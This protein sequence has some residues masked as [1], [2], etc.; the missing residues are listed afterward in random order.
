MDYEMHTM[1]TA[2]QQTLRTIELL[3]MILLQLPVLQ[4]FVVQRVSSTFR[5]T[6]QTSVQLKRDMWLHPDSVP[7]VSTELHI[8]PPTTLN[9]IL[10]NNGLGLRDLA[11]YPAALSG[12]TRW[13]M[14]AEG[15]W[16]CD[17]MSISQR[18][19]S[20]AAPQPPPMR[21]VTPSGIRVQPSWRNMLVYQG[22]DDILTVKFDHVDFS[23]CMVGVIFKIESRWTMGDLMDRLVLYTGHARVS[24]NAGWGK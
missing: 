21:P 10:F 1:E 15:K 23:G 8:R 17:L 6:I 18:D 19:W 5:D 22:A 7:A 11:G 4:R 3:E 13:A 16:E 9:P 14:W 20:K 12:S 2:T 24:T